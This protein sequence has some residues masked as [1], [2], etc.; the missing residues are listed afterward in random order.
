VKSWNAKAGCCVSEH[1]FGGQKPVLLGYPS[2]RSD[3]GLTNVNRI[4]S[5]RFPQAFAA[6][7]RF[8]FLTVALALVAVPTIGSA[9]TDEIQVYDA[10]IAEPGVINLMWHQNFTPDGLKSPAFPGAIISDH[11]YNGVPELAFGITPWFEQG[12]YLPVYSVSKGRGSTLDSVKLRELFAR[13]HAGDHTFLYGINFEFSYNASYW[14]V[15]HFT[16]EIRPIIGLHLHPWDIIIN[17]ILDTDWTGVRNYFFAPAIRL[18]YNY[19]PKWTF[20][21]EHYANYG[22]LRQFETGSGQYHA[23]WAVVDHTSKI[24]DVEAGVGFGLTPATDKVTLK[25]ML[26]RDIH[27]PRQPAEVA[28]TQFGAVP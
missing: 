13:P 24:M 9:Q 19:S 3:R 23:L 4:W 20:A 22:P 8:M 25:L 6:R 27:R 12:L 26:S 2:A 18:A 5:L 1:G 21:A 10:E 14:D 28:P 7:R 16:S 11:S 15:R 17:P